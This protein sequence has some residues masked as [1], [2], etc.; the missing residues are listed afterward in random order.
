LSNI[1]ECAVQC[2]NFFNGYTPDDA[3]PEENMGRR[4]LFKFSNGVVI[5]Y[6]SDGYFLFYK[7]DGS[8]LEGPMSDHWEWNEG[9]GARRSKQ[10]FHQNDLEMVM[11]T[12]VESFG[13]ADLILPWQD[14]IDNLLV[15][16]ELYGDMYPEEED[17]EAFSVAQSALKTLEKSV[18]SVFNSSS[19]SS[20]SFASGTEY[21]PKRCAFNRFSEFISHLES[22]GWIYVDGFGDKEAAL[23]EVASLRKSSKQ[24]KNAP[25][26]IG[27]PDINNYS[28]FPSGEIGELSFWV[29]SEVG[30]DALKTAADFGL[31]YEI[32]GESF[33]LN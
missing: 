13:K 21:L 6:L 10:P 18:Q 19:I 8:E 20:V 11:D 25:A 3:C 16:A 9:A 2:L 22:Q 28:F 7:A 14:Q 12:F 23:E 24:M 4:I 31:T 30:S 5:S 29:Q 1:I 33:S 27:Y 26:L 17:E 15:N 32:D